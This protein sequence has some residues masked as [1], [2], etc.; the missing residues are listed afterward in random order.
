MVPMFWNLTCL[1][2]ARLE[3]HRFGITG[4]KKEQQRVFEQDRA[5]MLG[6][7]VRLSI[8]TA[9]KHCRYQQSSSWYWD[10]VVDVVVFPYHMHTN[11][12]LLSAWASRTCKRNRC[13]TWFCALSH[14]FTMGNRIFDDAISECSSTTTIKAKRNRNFLPFSVNVPVRQAILNTVWLQCDRR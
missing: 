6:A 1:W 3:V 9:V 5:I 11:A 8:C 14:I 7:R 12:D 13:C 10:L 2:Q 4:Y